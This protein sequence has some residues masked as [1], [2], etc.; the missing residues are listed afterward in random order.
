MWQ[1]QG[2]M[3]KPDVFEVLYRQSLSPAWHLTGS[4]QRLLALTRWSL[5]IPLSGF[6]NVAAKF[7][8]GFPFFVFISIGFTP[9]YWAR[10]IR[11][12]AIDEEM[13][14]LVHDFDFMLRF[15]AMR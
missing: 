8:R 10:Y 11:S 1:Y 3:S 15:M 6:T 7:R 2:S 13:G 4:H 14:F 12:F 9:S 5:I